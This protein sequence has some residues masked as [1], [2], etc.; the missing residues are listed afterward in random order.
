MVFGF[1]NVYLE[2]VKQDFFWVMGFLFKIKQNTFASNVC[3]L[4]LA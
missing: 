1:S 3:F 2:V 4:P